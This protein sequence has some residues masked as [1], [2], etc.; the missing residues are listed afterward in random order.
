MTGRHAGLPERS[1]GVPASAGRCRARA[2]AR[3]RR[4]APTEGAEGTG[5]G[6]REACAG[7]LARALDPGSEPS[8]GFTPPGEAAS[9]EAGRSAAAPRDLKVGPGRFLLAEEH[10]V[11]ALA[12]AVR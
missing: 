6:V 5:T 7:M 3:S 10:A 1:A 2:G 4:S 8:V 11:D 12:A 9:N